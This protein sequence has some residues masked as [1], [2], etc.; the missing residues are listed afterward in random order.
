L[1]L[2]A[3]TAALLLPMTELFLLL[4]QLSGALPAGLWMALSMIGNGWAA[5]ALIF[6]LILFMP[7]GFYA[8][9]IATPLAGAASHL[10]KNANDALRPIATLNPSEFIVLDEGLRRNAMP[11]GHTITAF[12]VAAAVF[13]LLN[14]Q[15]RRRHYWLFLVAGLAGF[16]RIA[17]GVH[18]VEDVLVGAIVGLVSG[19]AAA[20]IARFIPEPALSP[21][22]WW[23]RV[24][25]VWGVFCFY[26]L[27][28]ESLDF[29]ANRPIQMLLALTTLMTLVV[30]WKRSLRL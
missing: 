1:L 17:V 20:A 3:S 23:L 7:R 11:S 6:P 21:A 29:D 27:L 12:A 2:P 26:S 22:S 5:F 4:N 9:V 16:A 18:W 13:F 10:I 14:A 19:W 30:F 28:T 15:Q 25:S 8:V 24:L